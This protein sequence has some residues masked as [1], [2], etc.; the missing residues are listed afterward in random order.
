MFEEFRENKYG[1]FD[2]M[3]SNSNTTLLHNLMPSSNP[4]D[5]KVTVS[6]FFIQGV[7]FAVIPFYSHYYF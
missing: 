3:S 2:W 6:I 1:F 4:G 5:R 7:C